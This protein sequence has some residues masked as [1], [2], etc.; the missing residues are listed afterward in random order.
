MGGD[1]QKPKGTKSPWKR[2]GIR[3]M[4][5]SYLCLFQHHHKTCQLSNQRSHNLTSVLIVPICPSS[6]LHVEEREREQRINCLGNSLVSRDHHKS[7]QRGSKTTYTLSLPISRIKHKNLYLSSTTHPSMQNYATC[8]MENHVN[9]L[10][11]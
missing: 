9:Y 3:T 2:D 4:L 11:S 8:H 1:Y 5:T 6:L 7:V 10:Y